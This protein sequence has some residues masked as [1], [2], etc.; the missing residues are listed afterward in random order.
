MAKSAE[1]THGRISSFVSGAMKVVGVAVVAS[2]AMGAGAA[3]KMA[4]DFQSATQ[5][6]VS[7]A[8][9]S[10]ADLE[11]VRAGVLNLMGQVGESADEMTRA[12]YTAS[13]AGFNFAN[14]G[15]EV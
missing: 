7:S 15:L 11:K 1:D 9:E 4:G 8:G 5:R 14:G 12:Y 13:S 10:Q 3:V 2:A 6:L